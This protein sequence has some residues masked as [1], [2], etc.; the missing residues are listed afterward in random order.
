MDANIANEQEIIQS[1]HTN[2]K[3]W[4]VAV[5]QGLIASRLL[6]TNRAIIDAVLACSP[7]SLLDLGCGEGWLGRELSTRAIK[8]LGV[9]A[10]PSLIEQAQQPGGAK[11][12]VRSYEDIA[13]G[14][15]QAKVDV[16]ACNFSLFGE[17]SVSRLFAYLPTL[18][19]PNGKLIVQ[20]LH[21]FFSAAGTPYQDG[22]RSSSWTGLSDDFSDPAPWY[23]RTLASWV[24]LF[25]DTG[26][27]WKGC[28]NR[29]I[30]QPLL[31]PRFFCR[32]RLPNSLPV[33]MCRLRLLP[34]YLRPGPASSQERACRH[35]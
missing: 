22:W 31:Q 12:R 27:T 6:A 21:P 8:V 7:Q 19:K 20:T 23:F 9:D 5:R 29:S 2:A 11:F 10:V 33:N 16:I 25:I 32:E 30:R 34:A 1:W 14:K 18:L 13:A 3:P 24:T 15:L 35:A 26:F 17:Q 28:K 4:T